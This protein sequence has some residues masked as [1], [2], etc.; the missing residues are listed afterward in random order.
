M[1]ATRTP[2]D[3]LA[4]I[5]RLEAAQAQIAAILAA[6]DAFVTEGRLDAA[7]RL[8]QDVLPDAEALADAI[9]ARLHEQ[10]HRDE[11]LNLGELEPAFRQLEAAC[12]QRWRQSIQTLGEAYEQLAP[13]ALAMSDD[14]TPF[15]TMATVARQILA[16]TVRTNVDDGTGGFLTATEI[17][18][19]ML[20]EALFPETALV[21]LRY[22]VIGCDPSYIALPL[23]VGFASAIGNSRRVQIKRGWTEPAV[24][25]G[26][27]I[28]E[29]GSMK[30]PALD[31]ALR[32]VRERQ[33]QALREHA[34]ALRAYDIQ[35]QNHERDLNAWRKA[36]GNGD[37]PAAPEP[38]ICERWLTD[39]IT[40]EALAMLLQ[41]NPRGLLVL[42]D[43]LSGWLHFDRY[44]AK[45]QGGEVA[46]WLETHRAQPLVVDRKTSGTLY[47]PRAAVSIIG[48][49]QPG[50]LARYVGQEHRD[51]GLLARLLLAMPPRWPKVWNDADIDPSAETALAAIFDALHDLAPEVN[52][53][54]EP[55]P[56]LV[57]LTPA[58]KQAWIKF[59]NKHNAE[60]DGLC[61]DLAAAW[62][63][64]EGYAARFALIHHLVRQ[65]TTDSESHGIEAIEAVSV[66]A[67]VK[68]SRW[69]AHEAGRVYAMLAE[70]HDTRQQR[71]LVDLIQRKGGS[72]TVREWQ[73]TRSHPSAEVAEAELAKLVEAGAGQWAFT[74]PGPRGGRPSHCFM[75][76][77]PLGRTI[78]MHSGAVPGSH[79]AA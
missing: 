22:K 24:L 72:V 31:L 9:A 52:A 75:L 56:V 68:L 3:V 45:G 44:S 12:E 73:R 10:M 4:L 17:L 66:D 27:I 6:M 74:P 64:L 32:V 55:Q 1:N 76:N 47:V 34:C 19:N 42:R 58:G 20:G 5:D 36:K 60:A 21:Q 46:K 13:A 40:I 48:G 50:I 38:P 41:D 28:G 43:E 77:G 39:D 15:S 79:D 23:L 2:A 69:F 57:T 14:A 78:Q 37:P 70:G 53:D 61:G 30:S 18:R 29:S 67:G 25:W 71:Q 65:V 51:N 16:G 33:G 59:Y 8:A 62:A 26:A 35:R 49:I 11:A 7:G 54:G 63:K